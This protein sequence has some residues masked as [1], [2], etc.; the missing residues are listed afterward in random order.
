MSTALRKENWLSGFWIVCGLSICIGSNRLSLGSLN[1]P[2]PGM[3][4]FIAGAVLCVLSMVEWWNTT[5]AYRRVAHTLAQTVAGGAAGARAVAVE[6]VEPLFA[7]RVGAFKAAAIIVALLVYA[8]TME[9]LGFILSTTLF[10]AFLLW[11]VERQR[12]YVIVFGA[13]LSSMATYLVFKVW[14]ETALPIGLLGF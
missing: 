1:D 7:N 8:L 4:P 5:R 10:I 9:H 11:L 6:A 14:L 13:V 12:W 3:F 2:G